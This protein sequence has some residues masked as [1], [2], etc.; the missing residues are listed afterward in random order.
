MPAG[1]HEQ[2]LGNSK[3]EYK[4]QKRQTQVKN[5]KPNR[6]IPTLVQIR[7]A[8]TNIP[9]KI[10]IPTKPLTP[11]TQ[12]TPR[13]KTPLTEL[14]NT[15]KSTPTITQPVKGDPR[16]E[17]GG[18]RLSQGQFGESRGKVQAAGAGE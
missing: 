4:A 5:N 3:R 1:R 16:G 10:P 8:L 6:R 7:P 14:R 12:T 15:E 11:V 9:H 18:A 17:G 2:T 13:L